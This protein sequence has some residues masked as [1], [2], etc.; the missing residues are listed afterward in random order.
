MVEGAGA[1]A[2]LS[3]GLGTSIPTWP[4]TSETT[5]CTGS[6]KLPVAAEAAPAESTTPATMLTNFAESEGI[7]RRFRSGWVGVGV[8]RS[9]VANAVRNAGS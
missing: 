8:T 9:S 7:I 5:C 4:T 6:G 3:L 1:S 2:L